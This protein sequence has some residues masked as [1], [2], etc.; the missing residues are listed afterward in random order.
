MYSAMRAGMAVCLLGGFYPGRRALAVTAPVPVSS[1]EMTAIRSALPALL[2]AALLFGC[3]AAVTFQSV[4]PGAPEVVTASLVRPPG[5]GP[6]PA[7]V[8][9]HGCGGLSPQMD[10]WARWL[11]ARGHVALV[12]DSFGPRRVSGECLADSPDDLALTTRF[13]DA[14]GGLRWLQSQPFVR[15]DR[16]AAMGF[17][18]GGVYAM[19]VVNGP[20][21]ERAQKRGVKLPE[22]GFA[23]AVGVYP[24]GCFSLVKEQVV[25]PLLVLIGEA[26][27]WTP[28]A[29]CR[30]MVDSMRTRGA[31]ASIVIY[32]GAYHYFDVEGQ[33]LEVLP[34]VGN[35]HKPGGRGATVSYQAEAAADAFRQVEA[36]LR[37]HLAP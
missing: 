8:L 23:A 36:F 31:E 2:L 9:L 12:V 21:L 14:M 25:R 3:T 26:D 27:D 16:V 35:D 19:A 5:P 13:D 24:G 1:S 11:A 7:V 22:P 29:V 32:P 18:Q 15:P 34:N 28:A 37:R 33:P 4:T 20:S 30:D 10:R 17:S 6:S